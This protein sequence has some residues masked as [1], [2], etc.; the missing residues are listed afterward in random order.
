MVAGQSMTIIVKQ[1]ATGT[2]PITVSNL[3]K[4]A[5][6]FKFFSGTANAIDMMNIFY[7][8]S[9]YYVTLTVNYG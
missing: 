5:Q 6:G 3:Y 8:G 7:D 1:D 9:I 2:R 4:F